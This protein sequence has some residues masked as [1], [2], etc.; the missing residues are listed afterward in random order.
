MCLLGVLT[1]EG[2]C[3]ALL[4]ANVQ[5]PLLGVCMGMQALAVANGATVQHAPEPIHGRLSQIQ[6]TNHRLFQ[7]IPSG[8]ALNSTCACWLLVLTA[9]IRLCME[10]DLSIDSGNSEICSFC[11]EQ[12]STKSL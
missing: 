1:V 2:V 7:D 4:K 8:A 12:R 9:I 5:L 10:L 11:T 6:H 3:A